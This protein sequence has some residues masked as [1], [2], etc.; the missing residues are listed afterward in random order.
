MFSSWDLFIM[1][2]VLK[3]VLATFCL[4]SFL[5][6]YI[7]IFFISVSSWKESASYIL[8]HRINDHPGGQLFMLLR[9][10]MLSLSSWPV[11][12]RE[13]KFFSKYISNAG[14]TESS[15]I[16]LWNFLCILCCSDSENDFHLVT[17][18]MPKLSKVSCVLCKQPQTQDSTSSH[19]CL[20]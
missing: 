7:V 13:V 16:I 17:I 9:T 15:H 19:H 2:L 1:V 5:A 12:I 20:F 18:N 11:F 6:K 10:F 8:K 14:Q 4:F 3:A